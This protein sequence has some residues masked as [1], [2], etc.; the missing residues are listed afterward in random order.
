MDEMHFPPEYK[1]A[2]INKTKNTTIRHN[3][4]G[5]HKEGNIYRAKSYAGKDWKINI[6]IIKIIPTKVNKLQDFNIPKK[7]INSLRRRVSSKDNVEII[8]F[9]II[10]S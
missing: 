3:Q 9:E 8:N 10:N 6:K 4:L 7:S 5:K 1:K 2:L